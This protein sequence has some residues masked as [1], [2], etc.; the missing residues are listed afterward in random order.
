M[1]TAKA[2][3][4]D[5]VA[6]FGHIAAALRAVMKQRGWKVPDFNEALGKTRGDAGIFKW[7]AARGAPSP[8]NRALLAE[9]TGIPEAA[10][11]PRVPGAPP[12]PSQAVALVEPPPAKISAAT[13]RVG[14]V[15]SFVVSSTGEARIRLDVS[16]PVAAATPLLRMLLDAGLVFNT[17]GE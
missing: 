2:A 13:V 11:R 4:R 5:E 12:P 10:L 3:T 15:L 8:A 16:L 17:G 6:R 7:L 1:P 14:D 9:V